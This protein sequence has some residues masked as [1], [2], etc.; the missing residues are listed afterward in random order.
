MI[1]VKVRY[2]AVSR[3]VDQA[4]IDR[5]MV[6]GHAGSG[7]Y[8][9]DLVCAAVSALVINFVN[10]VEGICGL[11]LKPSVRSGFMEVVVPSDHDIQLLARSLLFGLMELSKEHGDFI[12]MPE[13]Y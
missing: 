10:S 11:D 2:Q 12:S 6:K 4:P 13:S 9:H 8:G 3:H 7:D 1:R 5:L